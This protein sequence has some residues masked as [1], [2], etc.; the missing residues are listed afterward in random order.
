MEILIW[1]VSAV[2]IL[3]GLAGILIP[4]FPGMILILIAA[5]L[6]R[7]LIPEYLS[8]WTVALTALITT[9]DFVLSGLGSVAGAKWAGASKAGLVGAVAGLLVGL[10][11]LGPLGIILGPILGA[12]IAELV[13]AKKTLKK[14]SKAGLGTGAGILAST[15][16]RFALGIGAVA[17]LLADCF[18]S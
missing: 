11:L 3:A 8:W 17:A 18:L 15:A 2:L 9:A 1:I 6:H 14:A 7:L 5:V 13:V 16:L 10:L 4:V 12:I